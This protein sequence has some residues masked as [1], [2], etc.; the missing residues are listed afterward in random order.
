MKETRGE[1]KIV[2]KNIYIY[3]VHLISLVLQKIKIKIP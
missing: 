2:I 1:V 3:F